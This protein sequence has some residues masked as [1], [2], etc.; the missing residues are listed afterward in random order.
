MVLIRQKEV[1]SV[2]KR[3]AVVIETYTDICMLVGKDR[4]L[5]Y[6]YAEELLGHPVMTHDFA[7]PEIRNKLKELS[8]PEF[9]K[10]CQNLTD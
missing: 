1:K 8:K 6:K 4:N 3:E 7:N 10:I 2:T 5:A 9:I